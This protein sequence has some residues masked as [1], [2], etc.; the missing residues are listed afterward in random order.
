[1][2][3]AQRAGDRRR[4]RHRRGDG[5]ALRAAGLAVAV[6]YARDAAA[7]QALVAR[8]RARRAGR[9]RCRPT[10]RD[11]AQVLAM[12]ARIDAELPPLR[13][14]STTPAWSTCARVSTR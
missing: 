4:P 14:S 6:N 10:C 12:F 8:I 9:S 7:A 11:E 5:V 1:M 3:R 13:G 2:R